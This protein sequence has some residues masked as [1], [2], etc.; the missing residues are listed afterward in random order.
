[1]S[2]INYIKG[3]VYNLLNPK[4]YRRKKIEDFI[5]KSIFYLSGETKYLNI[6]YKFAPKGTSEEKYYLYE[7]LYPVYLEIMD[8]ILTKVDMIDDS[9]I[10]ASKTIQSE[11]ISAVHSMNFHYND[12]FKDS[13]LLDLKDYEIKKIVAG[14]SFLFDYNYI[15]LND[16]WVDYDKF[17][18]IFIERKKEVYSVLKKINKAKLY[19]VKRDIKEVIKDLPLKKQAQILNNLNKI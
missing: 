1:M 4:K 2:C 9:F 3:F 13:F 6:D 11:F 18:E 17:E 12:Q 14:L 19:K 15:N 7:I 8:I 10:N 5:N 16:G